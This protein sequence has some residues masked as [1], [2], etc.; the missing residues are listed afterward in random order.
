MLEKIRS[1]ATLRR[2]EESPDD[3]YM[4][5]MPGYEIMLNDQ[6]FDQNKRNMNLTESLHTCLQDIAEAIENDDL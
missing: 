3:N 1:E 5:G 2:R 6:V 4:I